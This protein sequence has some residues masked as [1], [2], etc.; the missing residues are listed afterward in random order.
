M[1][2]LG[3]RAASV[4]TGLA[5]AI[6]I[7]ALAILPFLTPQWV[8]FEQGR[9]NAAAW[10]GFTTPE[11]NTITGSILS[12][13]VFGPPDFRVAVAGDPVLDDRERGHMRDVRTVFTGLFLLAAASGVVLVLASRRTGRAAT[14]RAVRRGASGL[15]VAIVALGAVALVAFDALFEAFHEVLFPAGSYDFDPATE[16][17]V[18]LFPFQFWQETAI[19]VGVVIV[20]GCVV[21]A[22]AAG[23]RARRALRRAAPPPALAPAAHGTSP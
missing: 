3:A 7:V 21:V 9:A 17:L 8:S 13:L 5:T 12:D 18:Q 20:A 16:R 15:A 4:L 14:W 23:P 22:A 6:V 19:V 11:L 10:T 2:A 1:N